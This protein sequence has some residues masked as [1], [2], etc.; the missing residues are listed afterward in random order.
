[1]GG[2]TDFCATAVLVAGGKAQGLVKAT[3]INGTQQSRSQLETQTPTGLRRPTSL[4]ADGYQHPGE[5]SPCQLKGRAYPDRGFRERHRHGPDRHHEQV[6]LGVDTHTGIHVAAVITSTGALLDCGVFPRPAERYRQSLSWARALSDHCGGPNWNA[7]APT[8]PPC[9]AVCTTRASRSPR[10]TIP[11]R[12]PAVGTASP[13]LL[14]IV[15]VVGRQFRLRAGGLHRTW[16]GWRE[17]RARHQGTSP[18]SLKKRPVGPSAD[19]VASRIA[20]AAP[21]SGV[22]T[23]WKPLR[24]VAV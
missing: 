18:S 9:P 3:P 13:T 22:R 11:T 8:G 16:G 17:P 5:R 21:C 6:L 7:P 1:M 15:D 4:L 24:S 23:P 19:M 20:A 2:R 10:S 14:L 12:R